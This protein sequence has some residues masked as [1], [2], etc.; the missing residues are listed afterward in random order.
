MTFIYLSM[1]Q[2]TETLNPPSLIQLGSIFQTPLPKYNYTILRILSHTILMIRHNF[3]ST[4]NILLTQ[5]LSAV[6]VPV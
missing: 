5:R 6:R 1:G 3:F 2:T 4:N